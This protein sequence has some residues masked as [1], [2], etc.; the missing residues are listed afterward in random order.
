MRRLVL[1]IALAALPFVAYGGQPCRERLPTPDEVR[2]GLALAA[3]VHATLDDAKLA[4]VARVGRDLSRYGLRYSHVGIAWRGHPRGAWTVV[5]LLN[6]CGSAQS[7]LYDDGLGT[8]F[9]DDLFAYEAR[10]LVPSPAAQHRIAS[11][12]ARGGGA[13][14][15]E[16]RY[17]LVAYPFST[18]Y[19]NSNQWVLETLAAALAEQP[20]ERRADA[21]AWLRRTGFTPTTLHIPALERFGAEVARANIAFD[22]H[23]LARRMAG[24]IDV[25]SAESALAFLRL[26]DPDTTERVIRLLPHACVPPLASGEC[27]ALPEISIV[28]PARSEAR[29]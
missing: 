18:R 26:V 29:R 17:N 3:A 14:L 5:E 12:L 6:D 24:E 2:S 22:D 27:A 11:V 4:I 8:F 23:P 16:A 15:H 9:L 25:V 20:I 1:A 19:Q 7:A 13:R 28:P 10:V 21:Q